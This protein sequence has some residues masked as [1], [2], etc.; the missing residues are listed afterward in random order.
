MYKK[1]VIIDMYMYMYTVNDGE[2]SS[3]HARMR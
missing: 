3:S 1:Y 2:L